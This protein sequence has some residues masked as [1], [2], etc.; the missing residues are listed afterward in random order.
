MNTLET[1][2]RL[3]IE[4]MIQEGHIMPQ[5][6]DALLEFGI[7]AKSC[8]GIP[9]TI[10]RACEKMRF[11]PEKDFVKFSKQVVSQGLIK[12]GEIW[13]PRNYEPKRDPYLTEIVN[14]QFQIQQAA[15]A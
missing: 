6:E 2:T 1:V 15:C 10:R 3:V 11:L 12:K 7:C 9:K 4:D 8:T 5:E 14:I 13:I